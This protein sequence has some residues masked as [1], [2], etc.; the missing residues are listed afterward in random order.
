MPEPTLANNLLIF[1]LLSGVLGALGKL[2]W[3]GK[4]HSRKMYRYS[5]MYLAFIFLA[6]MLDAVM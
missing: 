1:I 6:L 2:V 4:I 3:W 5:S